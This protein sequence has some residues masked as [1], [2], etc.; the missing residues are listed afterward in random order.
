MKQQRETDAKNAREHMR[1]ITSECR[2]RN[3]LFVDDQFPPTNKYSFAN[4]FFL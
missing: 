4:S 3:A 2:Q 1:R